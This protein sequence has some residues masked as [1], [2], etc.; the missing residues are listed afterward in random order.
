MTTEITDPGRAM[1]EA[2]LAEFRRRSAEEMENHYAAVAEIVDIL[3]KRQFTGW[4]RIQVLIEAEHSF[5]WE[6][7]DEPH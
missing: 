5:P 7:H 1:Y 2:K 3:K 4:E 6:G